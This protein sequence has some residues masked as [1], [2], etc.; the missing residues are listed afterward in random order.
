MGNHPISVVVPTHGRPE[1]LPR[2]LES[3]TQCFPA[4]AVQ[5]LIVENG[6]DFGASGV[7]NG[8]SD[9]LPVRLLTIREAGMSAAQN[10]A[11]EMIGDD[12]VLFLNDDERVAASI[13]K[14]YR[15][16]I[17]EK[18]DGWFFGGPIFPDYEQ[19]PPDWLIES[20]PPSARG[21]ALGGSQ[22][23]SSPILLG[24][25]WLAFASDLKAAGGFDE[26]FG[27]GAKS[28][29]SGSETNMQE[30]LLARGLRG[31]YVPDA[32]VW[33]FVPRRRCGPWWALKRAY[34]SG[35]K[36]GIDQGVPEHP[37]GGPRPVLR[38]IA[39]LLGT[40]SRDLVG[41]NRA[42]A[43]SDLRLAAVYLGLLS[44]RRVGSV[45]RVVEE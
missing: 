27:P 43:F 10:A 41:G 37:E 6:G 22:E 38:R 39:G 21:F 13:L 4:A 11:L 23:V 18:R 42:A 30:R 12:A 35:R 33:H 2:L 19:P 20:L 29:A 17:S 7:V 16:A 28:L 1:L 34:R 44:G 9:R 5:V 26:R 45:A 3:L 24:G 31:W 25:N 14:A 8:F 40:F 32:G 15:D 36:W